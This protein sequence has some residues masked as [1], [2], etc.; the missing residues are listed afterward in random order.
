M[1]WGT[2]S[3]TCT[4][5]VGKY[6]TIDHEYKS[7]SKPLEDGT[8]ATVALVLF[9]QME[10]ATIEVI[11]TASS[12][13]ANSPTWPAIGDLVT[14]VDTTADTNIAATNW[15]VLNIAVKRAF[16]DFQKAT[17]KLARYAG[18]TS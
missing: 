3:T 13:G 16:N 4:A 11:P 6:Q 8:G 7:D 17:I 5:I 9:N 14:L 2:S 1:S 12:G 18:I 10:E 15:I